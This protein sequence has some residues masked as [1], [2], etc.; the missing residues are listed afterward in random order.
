MNNK[1]AI[2]YFL[3]GEDFENALI[4]QS[5]IKKISGEDELDYDIDFNADNKKLIMELN[6]KYGLKVFQKIEI[7]KKKVKNS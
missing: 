7:L 5:F 1:E 6:H 4:N 3:S 2:E